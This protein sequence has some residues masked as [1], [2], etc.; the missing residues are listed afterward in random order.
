MAKIYNQKGELLAARD[1]AR[2]ANK[3]HKQFGGKNNVFTTVDFSHSLYDG[4]KKR[5][6]G[7]LCDCGV[8]SNGFS[9]GEFVLLSLDTEEVQ[10]G[11]KAYMR[12]KKCGQLSHL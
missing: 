11:G 6:Y 1:V 8:D 9:S 2:W 7:H 12:C 4:G 5:L 10:S 3:V